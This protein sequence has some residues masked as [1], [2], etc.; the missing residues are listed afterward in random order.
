MIVLSDIRLESHCEHH[1][2]P[3]LGRAH[4]GHPRG[5]AQCADRM[6]GAAARRAGAAALYTLDRRAAQL[7]NAIPLPEDGPGSRQGADL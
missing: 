2:V 4:V 7:E 6:I 1:I 5:G 3:N